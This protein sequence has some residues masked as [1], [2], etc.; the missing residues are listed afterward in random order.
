M[1]LEEKKWWNRRWI[2]RGFSNL[3][4]NVTG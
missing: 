2:T 3:Y 4:P 1:G